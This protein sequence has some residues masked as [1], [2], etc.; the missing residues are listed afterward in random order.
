MR[1][2]RF[3]QSTLSGSL[4]IVSAAELKGAAQPIPRRLYKDGVRLSMIGFG[5]IVVMGHEQPE[6]NKLVASAYEKGINY[7]DVAP[8][9]GDGEAEIKLGPALEPY[10][11]NVFLAC[12][13]GRRGAAAA[14]QELEQSLRRLKTDHFDLYQMHSV[15]TMQDVEQILGPNGAAETFLQAKKEGKVR[16]LGFS[17]HNEAAAEAL[18]EKFPADSILFPLNYV[19]WSQGNFGPRILAKAKQKGVARLALKAMAYTPWPKGMNRAERSCPTC[20]YQPLDG[21][22]KTRKALYFTLSQDITA[23]VPPGNAELF[24]LALELAAG[25]KPLSKTEQRDVLASAQ[26]VEPIF[27]S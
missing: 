10:R 25:F 5:G 22:E 6:A 12:K 3:L 11:K 2:R 16:Y 7:F 15:S 24:Q 23:A 4:A 17:A 19:C 1:R 8:S 13:T 20:W 27:R 26:G 21:R 18:L 14:R 9:Y